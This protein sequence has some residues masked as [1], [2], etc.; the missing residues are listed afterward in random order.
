MKKFIYLFI[1]AIGFTSCSVE[2]IDSTEN[3]LT[4]DARFNAQATSSSEMLFEDLVCMGEETTITV[5]FPQRKNPQGNNQPTTVE[6]QLMGASGWVSIY[7]GEELNN[8]TTTSFGYTFEEEIT[9]ALRY[10]I[11][12]NTGWV[13]PTQYLEVEDCSTCD[14]LLVADLVCGDVNKL[15]L[16]F[17]ALEE[18]PIVIQGGLNKWAE[19]KSAV[20]VG[21]EKV[22]KPGNAGSADVTRWAGDVDA[23]EVVTITIEF[24][25][26]YEIGDW[27]AK[28]GE[29]LLG[30]TDAQSCP[31]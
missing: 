31:E 27:T 6:V 28:R 5:N 24:E 17:T 30:S 19:I 23:C 11:T 4:A 2:S 26:G 22:D 15:T 9:Y 18:G 3:L 7:L 25:G 29:D 8:T 14:N 12:G 21:V 10:K 20:G 13:N 16:T 1:L